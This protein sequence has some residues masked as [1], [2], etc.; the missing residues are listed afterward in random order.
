MYA[1]MG[2]DGLKG[3]DSL[4]YTSVA[5]NFAEALRSAS[6]HGSEWFGQHAYTMPL[7]HWLAAIPY[8]MFGNIHG[9]LAYIL[10]QGVFD[11]GTCV[12]VY[13]LASRISPRVAV[14]ASLVAVVNPT[15]IVLS[16]LFYTD[17]PFVFFVVLSFLMAVQWV[18]KPS[19]RSA[20]MLGLFLGCAALI[21]AIIVPWAFFALALLSGYVLFRK[22]A[23]HKATTIA[24]AVMA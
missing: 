11:A 1:L 17:T 23:F 10:M 20:L 22:L 19:W 4:T 18:E 5:S 24:A 3:L 2:D 13:S 16:G 8:L 9:T 12:A 15:Q 14:A 6:V 21:R 7:Y